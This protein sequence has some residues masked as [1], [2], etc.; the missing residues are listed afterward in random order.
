MDCLNGEIGFGDIKKTKT[1]L[2]IVE[3]FGVLSSCEGK[4]AYQNCKH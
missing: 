4:D 3:K 2:V 1:P